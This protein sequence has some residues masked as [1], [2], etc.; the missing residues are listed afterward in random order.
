LEHSTSNSI[1]KAAGATLQHLSKNPTLASQRIGT[2][3]AES[4]RERKILATGSQ[5]GRGLTIMCRDPDPSRV[6]GGSDAQIAMLRYLPDRIQEVN[7]ARSD[8]T[9]LLERARRHASDICQRRR[10]SRCIRTNSESLT[11]P[12][13]GHGGLMISDSNMN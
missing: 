12:Q 4:E 1:P 8:L 2:I 7:E 13:R 10:F 3:D 9:A 6:W 5:S 11:A